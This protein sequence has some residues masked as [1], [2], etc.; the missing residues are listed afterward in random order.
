[1]FSLYKGKAPKLGARGHGFDAYVH[2]FK[3]E[4]T[5]DSCNFEILLIMSSA[6]SI[7]AQTICILLLNSKLVY[8][9]G[10][11]LTRNNMDHMHSDMGRS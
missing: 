3:K 2:N 6:A 7:L 4:L 1:M 5:V 9:G 10:T 11:P 8:G